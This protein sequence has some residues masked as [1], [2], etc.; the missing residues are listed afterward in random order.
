MRSMTHFSKSMLQV[1]ACLCVAHLAQADDKTTVKTI[2]DPGM[3]MTRTLGESA[4]EWIKTP[5]ARLTLKKTPESPI[6]D[7]EEPKGDWQVL[8]DD[9]TF[10]Q[11]MLRWTR[12]AGWQL[13]WEV[14]R[15]FAIDAQV[16]LHGTFLEVLDISMR[17]LLNTDYPLQAQVNEQT[18]VLRITRYMLDGDRR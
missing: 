3:A 5:R 7:A 10:Y 2:R 18:R 15:D 14:E 9:R 8:L 1:L 16:S 4:V 6:D 13:V 17:S 12:L 11:T